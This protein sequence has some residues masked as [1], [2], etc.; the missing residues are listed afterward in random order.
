MSSRALTTT[1][2]L[3]RNAIPR[4]RRSTAVEICRPK[5]ARSYHASVLPTLVST[6]SPEFQQ[7]AQSMEQP[8]RELEEKTAEA[9][10][11]GGPKAIER[12][13]SKGKK[14]PRE[15]CAQI[16]HTL[17]VSKVS[18]E[19]RELSIV[20]RRALLLDPHTPFLELSSLAAYGVYVPG[21]GIITGIGRIS[22]RECMIVVNDATVKGGSYY[23]LT[24]SLNLPIPSSRRSVNMFRYVSQVKKHLRAQ[25]IAR[26]NGL[27]CV[28]GG[29]YIIGRSK[30]AL[31]VVI[32]RAV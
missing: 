13:R 27:P 8:I 24:V 25:E 17:R 2:Y 32:R 31:N 19:T 9:R 3:A 7:N 18:N 20:D 4:T 23:P 30:A 12:M 11:G 10:I 5:H 21:A 29:Q 6:T 22:G 26:E 28:Y 1:N 14:L 15:R 16:I